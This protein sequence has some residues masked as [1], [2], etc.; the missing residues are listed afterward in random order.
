MLHEILARQQHFSKSDDPAEK[1]AASMARFTTKDLAK[2]FTDVNMKAYEGEVHLAAGNVDKAKVWK[3]FK[4]F[5]RGFN[6]VG[7]PDTQESLTRRNVLMN[8]SLGD[9][10]GYDVLS[11]YHPDHTE[12]DD[13]NVEE[14]V[15]DMRAL[16]HAYKNQLPP[17]PTTG[18]NTQ[19]VPAPPQIDLGK[20]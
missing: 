6:G 14:W 12:M 3:T 2:F 1:T 4:D 7:H 9:R 8:V 15:K 18:G 13:F 19:T 20:L 16:H 10:T 17:I 11:R 5:A